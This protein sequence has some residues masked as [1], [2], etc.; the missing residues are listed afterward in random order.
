MSVKLF[1]AQQK[2]A[3]SSASLQTVMEEDETVDRT[4]VDVS[5]AT[6]TLRPPI[7]LDEYPSSSQQTEIEEIAPHYAAP[8]TE[9]RGLILDV[10]KFSDTGTAV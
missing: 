10:E 6:S 5:A 4:M 8:L 7:V 1:E 3:T 9:V 2:T